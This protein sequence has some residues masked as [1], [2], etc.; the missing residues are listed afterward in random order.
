MKFNLF[1]LLVVASVLAIAPDLFSQTTFNF[2]SNNGGFTTSSA[3]PNVTDGGWIYGSNVGVG[4]SG[5]WSVA[6]YA[7]GFPNNNSASLTSPTLTVSATGAVG[8]QFDSRFTFESGFDGGLVKISINGGAFQELTAAGGSFSAF[9]Y[10]GTVSGGQSGISGS[11]FTGVSSGYATPSYNTSIASINLTAGQTIKFQFFGS[12]DPATI[13]NNPDFS[14]QTPNWVI[15]NV[16]VS[17]A[18]PEPQTYAG[19]AGLAM[20]GWATYR[21]R[22]SRETSPTAPAP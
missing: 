7:A 15:D 19:I 17:N 9:G 5:G 16:S 18:V 14:D 12:W 1:R 4:G 2:N 20:L 6:G 8:L 22:L 11:A 10:N 13:G 3:G 21:R